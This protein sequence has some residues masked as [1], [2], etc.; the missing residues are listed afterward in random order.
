MA[1][2]AVASCVEIAWMTSPARMRVIGSGSEV[3]R[4]LFGRLLC[5]ALPS[6]DFAHGDLSRSKQGPE[7]HRRRLGRGQHGLRLDTA[8]E[9]LVQPLD[10]VGRARR[11]PLTRGQPGESEQPVA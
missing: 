8:L 5:E 9:L 2:G 11:L 6:I 4:C 10:R 7:Q 3:N 1:P